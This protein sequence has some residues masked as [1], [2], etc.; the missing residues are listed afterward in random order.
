H[1][2]KN[3]AAPGR[4]TPKKRLNLREALQTVQKMRREAQSNQSAQLATRSCTPGDTAIVEKK[5][6]KDDFREL[7]RQANELDIAP[8]WLC[9]AAWMRAIDTWNISRASNST[10][11]ISLEVP[12][13]LRRHRDT[14]V[15]IGNWISPL[16]LYGDASQPL[17]V[18]ATQLRQQLSRTVRQR[19]H[20]ALPLVSWPAKF[21]PWLLFRRLAASPELTG[22]A[23]SHF[24][25]F[26]QAQTLHDD[27]MRL[28]GGALQL[29]DQQIYPPVCLH[30]GA[31]LSVLAWPE[32]AQIFLTYR[33]TALSPPEARMLLDLLVQ[34]LPSKHLSRRQ[35]A[36]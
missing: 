21:L 24:A 20:L 25:W 1:E 17:K 29:V 7:Q 8:G 23:T 4:R 13:S 34:E 35:V 26:E 11:L 27:T 2:I 32:R 12:V 16:T 9:A 5:L 33:L 18:L 19:S 6:E 14:H 3:K 28:S 22:F 36:V 10:S 31:A 30:M 15:R